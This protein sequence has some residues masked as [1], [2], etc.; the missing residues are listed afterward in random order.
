MLAGLALGV[1]LLSG[2]G[3]E[4]AST[5]CGLNTCAITFDRGVEASANVLGV[6]ARLVGV[7]GDQVIIEVAGEQLSLLVGQQGT[8]VGGFTV[9]LDSLTDEQVTI[10]VSL[11]PGG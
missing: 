11:N 7:Q 3:S 9:T 10:R 8:E 6:E 2:C 4:G 1:A 5:D